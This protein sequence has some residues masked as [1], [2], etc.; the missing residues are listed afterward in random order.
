MKNIAIIPARSGSKRIPHKNIRPFLGRPI[1]SYSIQAALES[2]CF[3]VVM[4]STDSTEIAEIALAQGAEVPF[5][6]SQV[7]SNDY[8]TT[9]DVIVEVLSEY[10]NRETSFESFCCL[11]STAPFIT[12]EILKKAYR[13]LHNNDADSIIPVARYH[14]PILR[15]FSRTDRGELRYNYP[16]HQNSRSQDLSSS[17][18]DCGQFY[19]M[20]VE[21]FLQNK[22]LVTDKTHGILMQE[23]QI[24]DIDTEED[25]I[26]AEIKYKA[27][28]HNQ[29]LKSS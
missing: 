8:A 9:S 5:L 6:R 14:H 2:A 20:N 1:I 25:W 13:Q 18:Y 29:N 27:L 4:V 16:Q 11:Y 23:S 21:V 28:Y 17:Y 12:G 19:W 7:N 24:Q 26:M 15:S 22:S 3:D 10:Q